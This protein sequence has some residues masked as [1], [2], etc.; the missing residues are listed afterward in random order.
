MSSDNL[1]NL[2]QNLKNTNGTIRYRAVVEL[3]KLADKQTVLPLLEAVL[4]DTND[5]VI[6]KA[7][8]TLV[9]IGDKQIIPS[10]F[11]ML[12]ELKDSEN[13]NDRIINNARSYS[14]ALILGRLGD[15]NLVESLISLLKNNNSV[16]RGGAA[17]TLSYLNDK[18]ALAPLLEY[19]NDLDDQVRARVIGAI[20]SI[21]GD[22]V[23]GI[24]IDA[25]NND[26]DDTVRLIAINALSRSDDP[27]A[28]EALEWLA[29][30]GENV[31]DYETDSISQAAQ[32]AIDKIKKPKQE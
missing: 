14:A 29:E 18:R 2:L 28:L 32:E 9:K 20:G 21:G 27:Q 25:A 3:Q 13:T 7:A 23:L 4:R 31:S 30:N 26:S 15:T 1:N 17:A 10:I 5:S 6:T 24:L 16:V 12:K 8:A 22:E 19:V 11:D